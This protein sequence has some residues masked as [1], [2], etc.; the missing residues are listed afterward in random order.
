MSKRG[1]VFGLS[2]ALLLAALWVGQALSQEAERPRRERRM[3]RRGRFDAGQMRQRMLERTKELLGATDEDWKALGPRIEK[4][5]TLSSQ[6]RGGRGMGGMFMRL[7]SRRGTP[8]GPEATPEPT[9]LEK[10]LQEL[11]TALDNQEAE[12]KDIQ[13]KLT[14]LREARQKVQEELAEAQA[15]LRELLTVRQEAQLVLWGMLD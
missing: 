5:Q 6:L 7:S 13:E 2:V 11:R 14:A 8:E 9:E 3:M 12:P 1:V 15:Q 4:V 10:A